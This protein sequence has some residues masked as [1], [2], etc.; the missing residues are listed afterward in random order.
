MSLRRRAVL[1]GSLLGAVLLACGTASA[2]TRYPDRPGDVEAG[3]GPDM[4]SMTVSNSRTTIT[5]RFRFA[6]APPL[7]VGQAGMWVDMLL[8]A[9][10]VPPLGPPPASP[11]GEWR[12]ADFAFGTHGPSKTGMLVRLGQGASRV[13]TRFEVVTRGSTLTFSIP[14]R[15]LGSPAW[16]AFSAAAAREA[17]V[18]PAAGAAPDLVPARGTYRYTLTG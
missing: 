15:S 5:F 13:V 1:G 10:D 14:R 9:V 18:E 4:T 6:T 2:T 12:G 17:A 7:R 3:T 16:F 8:V 11:G